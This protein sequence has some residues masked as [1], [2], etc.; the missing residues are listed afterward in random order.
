[1]LIHFNCTQYRLNM[2]TG[3]FFR[4]LEMSL[5]LSSEDRTAPFSISMIYLRMLLYVL[6]MKLRVSVSQKFFCSTAIIV[7]LGVFVKEKQQTYQCAVVFLFKG[8][9]ISNKMFIL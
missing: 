1:M 6:S 3:L 4:G 2:T 7:L 8:S 9:F 5:A